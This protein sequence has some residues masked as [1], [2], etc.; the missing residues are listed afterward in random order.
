[1]TRIPLRTLG[2]SELK[3]APFALGGNV[4]GWTVDRPT[5]FRILDAFVDAGFNLIDTADT[6]SV[7]IDGHHGGESETIIGE[8]LRHSGRRDDVLVATK[9]GMDMGPGGKGLSEG[10][11]QSS[12]D[13]SLRRLQ[14]DRIDLYQAHRDDPDTPLDETLGAFG[15]LI[16]EGKVRVIGASN[17]DADRLEEALLLSQDRG[18]PRFESLQP[19][20][21]LIDREAFETSLEPVCRA[22]GLGVLAYSSLASGF[23]S[24]KYRST[25][26]VGKSPRGKSAVKRLDARGLRI[27]A[28]LDAVS[29]RLGVRPATI[30]LAWLMARPSVTAPIASVTS[31][32]QLRELISAATLSLD[33]AALLEL[34][35]AGQPS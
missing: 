19:R 16:E 34:E 24:G 22:E 15:D 35:R 2:R 31:I 30:A 28:A 12:I 33:S 10:H 20:Y 5:G 17:Y 25:E 1:M 29:G 26:D 7:W 11:I 13:G 27:L 4:F 14:T 18:L 8:W 23:L 9:V 3:V 6:Y 21:N 32:D